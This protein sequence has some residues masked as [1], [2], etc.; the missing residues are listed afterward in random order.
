MR[1]LE[2][3]VGNL[4]ASIAACDFEPVAAKAVEASLAW[5]R[6]EALVCVEEM[7]LSSK[8][9]KEM[10]TKMQTE[11]DRAAALLPKTVNSSSKAMMPSSSRRRSVS[12]PFRSRLRNRSSS[13]SRLTLRSDDRAEK[14]CRRSAIPEKWFSDHTARKSD[15]RDY[16]GIRYGN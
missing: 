15:G 6:V 7:T 3:S 8:R 9:K 11:S 4:N 10:Q 12:L 5:I 16:E 1:D 14:K 2:D 13:P